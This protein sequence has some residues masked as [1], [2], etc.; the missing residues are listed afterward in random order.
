MIN[1]TNFITKG[2]LRGVVWADVFQSLIML[3]GLTII[4]S[5]VCFCI[6]VCMDYV[7][8]YH[9]NTCRGIPTFP[10]FW[11]MDPVQVLTPQWIIGGMP[12]SPWL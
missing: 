4:V 11:I 8:W 9:S 7:Y 2:G 5:M 3:G 1:T 10:L 12:Y 6:P